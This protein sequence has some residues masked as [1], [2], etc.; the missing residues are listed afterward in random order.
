VEKRKT[1]MRTVLCFFWMLSTAWAQTPELNVKLVDYALSHLDQK[2][3]HGVCRE[4]VYDGLVA[5]GA[6][7]GDTVCIDEL[8]PGDIYLTGGAIS[9]INGYSSL[10]DYR[11]I[12]TLFANEVFKKAAK[13]R[14][15]IPNIL[16]LGSF[17]H[18]SIVYKVLGDGRF[19][20][21]EQNVGKNL[22]ESRVVISTVDHN[23]FSYKG[24]SR[25]VVDIFAHFIRPKAGVF[26]YEGE[27]K[28][29]RLSMVSV[30]WNGLISWAYPDP[31]KR[32]P[33]NFWDLGE[34]MLSIYFHP[35]Y[36]MG[37][38]KCVEKEQ[39]AGNP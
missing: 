23:S 20:V 30:W 24:V 35:D 11:E 25:P 5:I 16:L 34:E 15:S 39:M 28:S 22:R 37:S 18:I 9:V 29:P 31:F 33:K 8:K 19:M 12:D 21:L 38:W 26:D 17:P 4:L 27:I 14:D 3:G 1:K 32:K 6:T 36:Q 13:G 2:V 10:E 7:M